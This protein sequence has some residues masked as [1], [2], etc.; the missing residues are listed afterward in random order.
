M[1]PDITSRQ[2][3]VVRDFKAAA[4]RETEDALLDGWHLLHD[5]FASGLEITVVAVSAQ[6]G[7][8]R[9]RTLLAHLGR[10]SEVVTVTASVMNALS[11]TRTPSGIVALARPPRIHVQDLLIPA[12]PLVLVAVDVQDPG[13]AGAIV[14]SAEAGGATG[15]LLVGASADPWGWKALRA[16]MG[17]TFRL[18]VVRAADGMSALRTLQQA[19]LTRIAAVPRG[20]T[21]MPAANLRRPI[22]LVLGGEGAGLDESILAHCDERVS[23]PMSGKAESLNVAV[24]A[25]LLVYESRRQRLV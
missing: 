17:S 13:N 9:D 16:S 25:A 24:A 4:Q 19:G 2:H 5:A 6:P 1:P 18:P 3:R 10:S 20:A 21:P 14:R 7:A 12:P 15:V 22:A 11:P 8:E 23:I